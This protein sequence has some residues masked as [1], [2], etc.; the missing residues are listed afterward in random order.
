MQFR[1]LFSV[2]SV[3]LLPGFLLA[4]L[5]F[6]EDSRII[7]AQ[8]EDERVPAAFYFVNSGDSV[9]EIRDIRTS[10]GCT[11]AKPAKT[12]FQPGESGTIEAEFVI[13]SR[14]GIQRNRILVQTS[15]GDYS[16]NLTV[17][18][19]V[20]WSIDNRILVWRAHE[21][22]ITKEARIEVNDPRIDSVELVDPNG[23]LW[24]MR[25]DK[26]DGG[27]ALSAV[28]REFEPQQRQVVR[29][30]M[31]SEDGTEISSTNLFLRML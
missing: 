16:L 15:S 3:F 21:Q 11:A 20:S 19:P 25:I 1:A 9:V 30:R 28:P 10:C 29:L 4:E 5:V 17:N 18:I 31:L 26:V 7:D 8:W 23:S 13:G 12:H 2:I 24:S 14:Q 27:W 22:Q 6:E